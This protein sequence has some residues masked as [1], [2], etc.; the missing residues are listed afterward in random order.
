[1]IAAAATAAAI[2]ISAAI[3]NAAA[4]AAAV[5]KRKIA[6][7]TLTARDTETRT[8]TTDFCQ[9]KPHTPPCSTATCYSKL[10]L[11]KL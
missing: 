2:A 9:N 11:E 6:A 4:P 8:V 7:P 3:T 1:M 5:D 10:P